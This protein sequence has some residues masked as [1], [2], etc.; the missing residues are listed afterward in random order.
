MTLFDIGS[1]NAWRLGHLYYY[2]ANDFATFTVTAMPLGLYFL[3]R[4]QRRSVRL[5]AACGLV[6]L[7]LGYVRSGSRGGFIA[8]AAVAAYIVFCFSSIPL[9]RR[10]LSTALVIVVL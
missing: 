8:L 4:G 2:D 9:R 6:L 5:F 10:L 7:T 1:G 3:N